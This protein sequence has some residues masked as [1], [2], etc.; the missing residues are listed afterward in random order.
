[1]LFQVVLVQNENVSKI[2]G[3]E[4]AKNASQQSSLFVW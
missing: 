4:K 1:M 2:N 3:I